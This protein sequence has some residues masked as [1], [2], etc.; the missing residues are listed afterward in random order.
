[1]ELKYFVSL[2]V[3][4]LIDSK[5]KNGVEMFCLLACE[6][7]IDRKRLKLELKC[8]ASSPVSL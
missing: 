4:L 5:N 6:L 3:C 7:V 1:M 2:P 8:F